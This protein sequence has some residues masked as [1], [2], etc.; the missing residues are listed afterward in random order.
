MI[1]VLG[2]RMAKVSS[3]LIIA[4]LLKKYTFYLDDE[5]LYHEDVKFDVKSFP[6]RPDHDVRLR[7]KLRKT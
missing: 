7:A 5:R 4:A 1:Y 2:M 3:K 6:L